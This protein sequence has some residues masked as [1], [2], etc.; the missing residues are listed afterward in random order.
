[1]YICKVITSPFL[2][3]NPMPGR[4]GIWLPICSGSQHLHIKC[5]EKPNY[6]LRFNSGWVFSL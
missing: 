1:M 3:V 2:H 6:M 5:V 4:Y